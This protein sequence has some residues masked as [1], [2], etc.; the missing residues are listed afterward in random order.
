MTNPTQRI[1]GDAIFPTIPP[2]FPTLFQSA[3][4]LEKS[5]HSARPA[6]RLA[7]DCLFVN[8]EKNTGNITAWSTFPVRSEVIDGR[9]Y[10][11][12]TILPFDACIIF[13]ASVNSDSVMVSPYFALYSLKLRFSSASLAKRYAS[14][15]TC[16]AVFVIGSKIYPRRSSILIVRDLRISRDHSIAVPS[17]FIIS[18]PASGTRSKVPAG[19]RSNISLIR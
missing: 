19:V 12:F 17:D 3:T 5:H 15:A 9:A 4:P 10:P 16:V 13:R 1:I 2:I 18:V 8:A 7:H 14:R 6:A 11:A